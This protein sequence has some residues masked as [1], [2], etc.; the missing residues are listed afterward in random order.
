MVFFT[1]PSGLI[2]FYN[3]TLDDYDYL[4]PNWNILDHIG[5]MLSMDHVQESYNHFIADLYAKSVDDPYFKRS[6][7][8][9]GDIVF[10]VSNK[11]KWLF[12]AEKK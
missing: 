8:M 12:Q 4:D 2:R 3:N 5:S 6:V 11:C 9:R 10:D 7:R 1:S